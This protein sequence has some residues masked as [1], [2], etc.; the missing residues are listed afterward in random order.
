MHRAILLGIVLALTLT[1]ANAINAV[2]Q[3]TIDAA[4]HPI[5]GM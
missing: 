4:T 3:G 5:V 1:G 2:A